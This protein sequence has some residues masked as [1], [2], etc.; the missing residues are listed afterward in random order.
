MCERKQSR[1]DAK[2]CFSCRSEIHLEL[3]RVMLERDG[4]HSTGGNEVRRFADGERAG[5]LDDGDHLRIAREFGTADEE[6]VTAADLLIVANPSDRDATTV[7][8]R[9]A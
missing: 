9:V 6:N 5:A 4:E 7:R 8:R 3:N 1:A 2:V